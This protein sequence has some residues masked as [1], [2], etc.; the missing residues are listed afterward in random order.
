[1]STKPVL[2]TLIISPVGLALIR[3]FET[4][5]PVVYL[6]PAGYPTIGYGHRV[7]PGEV[8][9]KP[10][11]VARGES[12]LRLDCAKA[13]LAIRRLVEVELAQNEFDALVSLV[14][15]VGEEAFRTS[16]MLLHLNAGNKA[17]AALEFDDWFY[18]KGKKLVGLVRRRKAEKSLFQ[19]QPK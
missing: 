1:M 17:A 5:S 10:I 2:N 8:F 13:E 4:F 3:S 19:G 15:N 6:C 11:S 7:L 9:G 12:L 16:K 18:A 14:F